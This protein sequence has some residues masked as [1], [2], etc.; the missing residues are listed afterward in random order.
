MIIVVS[1][2]ADCVDSLDSLSSSDPIGLRCWQVLYTASS[3][4][5]EPTNV[6]FCRSVST[7]VLICR[8][9]LKNIAND[10][11]LTSLKYLFALGCEADF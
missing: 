7:S 5:K 9:P 2:P 10:F 6:D 1:M 4:G 3:V 8:I 11:V